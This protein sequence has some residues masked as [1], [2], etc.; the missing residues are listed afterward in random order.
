LQYFSASVVKI[1]LCIVYTREM[2][3]ITDIVQWRRNEFE[4][5]AHVRRNAVWVIFLFA[6]L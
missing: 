5:G 4:S 6:V 1:S 3:D 2:K